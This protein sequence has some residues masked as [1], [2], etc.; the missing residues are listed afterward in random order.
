MRDV[1]QRRLQLQRQSGDDFYANRVRGA[2]KQQRHSRNPNAMYRQTEAEMAQHIE[3]S[4]RNIEGMCGLFDG[5]NAYIAFSLAAEI[6]KVLTTDQ[7]IALFRAGC[8]FP[9]FLL[10]TAHAIWRPSTS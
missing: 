7:N 1:A 9:R 6:H 10:S 8:A 5:G 4:V 3:E 2:V